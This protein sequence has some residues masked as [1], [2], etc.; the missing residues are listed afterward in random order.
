MYKGKAVDVKEVG[1]ELG[2]RYA[3]EGSVRRVGEAITVN[4]QLISTETGA[5]V[6][7]DRFEGERAKLGQLQVEIVARLA[8]ALK[9]ELVRAEALRATRERRDNPDA[10]DLAM[11][12]WVAIF[13]FSPA[14]YEEAIDDFE[15]AL[16]LDPDL[17]RAKLGLS[18]A[19][20]D[21][22]VFGWSADPRGNMLR[23][24]KL[25]DEALSAEPDN[26]TAH[27]VKA[28]YQSLILTKLRTSD[29]R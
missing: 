3:L 24:E 17:V 6:W 29:G 23:A 12:G 2:V 5:H 4:A 13:R 11:R 26:A 15:R 28:V 25:T 1:R 19:F 20:A 18:S 9:V 22:V 7:A 10:V 8:N 16:R 27:F 21:E 14:S